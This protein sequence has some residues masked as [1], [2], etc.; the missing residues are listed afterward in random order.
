VRAKAETISTWAREQYD[1]GYW[2]G[3]YHN[4]DVIVA[5]F[6][7]FYRAILNN[8]G[9]ARNLDLVVLDDF[10]EIYGGFR[11]P[12]I[13]KSI[14]AAMYEGIEVFAMS[15]TVGNPEELASWMDA[16]CTVSPEGRQIEIEERA[17]D[18]A[19]R[20]KKEAI[21]DVLR[22]EEDK[23]PFLVFNYAKPWTE[24]RAKQVAQTRIFETDS[25]RDYRREMRQK[26]NGEVTETLEDLG[27]MMNAGVAFHHA[28]LPATS[29]S[30]SSTSTRREKSSVC[31]R[32]Q[33]SP[34]GST[35]PSRASSLRISPAVRKMSVSGSTFSGSGG[36]PV[37]V[38]AMMLATRTR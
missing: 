1:I 14:G 27:A 24:S 6:D 10:H 5:T 29:R 32:Q 22:R 33:L 23:A 35:R 7:S 2:E 18:V 11:G 3:A 9:R 21:V 36:Q 8:T 34:T 15:A 31:S 28:D 4:S 19:G 25:D 38:T 12:E 17:I 13:E 26:V 37:P 30:G 20:E 16:D